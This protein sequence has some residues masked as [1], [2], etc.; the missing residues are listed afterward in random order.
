VVGVGVVRERVDIDS[1]P[2][3]KPSTQSAPTPRTRVDAHSYA[4]V[5]IP[6]LGRACHLVQHGDAHGRHATRCLGRAGR[7]AKGA[8]AHDVRVADRLDLRV[9][10][11]ET[12]S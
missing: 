8:A 7:I 6:F 1:T 9:G 4:N 12:P 3:V 10:G 2:L 5:D 11:R